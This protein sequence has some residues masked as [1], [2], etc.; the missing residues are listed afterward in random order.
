MASA[1]AYAVDTSVAIAALD[2]GH[3]A[4]LPCLAAV[5]RHRP[6]LA[7]HAAYEVYAVLTRLPG[8]LAIGAGGAAALI[9]RVFPE[10]SWLSTRAQSALR[11]RLAAMGIVGGAVY[12][13]LVGEAA[14]SHGLTLLTRDLRARRTYDL[15]GV[16]HLFVGS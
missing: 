15:L 1:E 5:Q 6:A 8:D 10:V 11:Q 13:A 9:D 16:D 12:D 14:R 2:A 7:G 4:H 3:A